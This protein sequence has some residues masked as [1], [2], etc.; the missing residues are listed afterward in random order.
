MSADKLKY[1]DENGRLS[2]SA[3][4]PHYNWI[5]QAPGYMGGQP[6]VFGKRVSVSFILECIE[7]GLTPDE[8]AQDYE[9]PIEAVQEALHFA[10][11]VV[12]ERAI[13]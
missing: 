4:L 3:L 9:V 10:S 12:G 6:A 13:G 8:V 2:K 1:Y 5:C 7:Q 11:H